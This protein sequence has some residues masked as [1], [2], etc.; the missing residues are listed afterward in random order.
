MPAPDLPFS[1]AAERNRGPILEV[2]RRVLPLRASVLEI[3]SGTGQHAEQRFDMPA[4]NLMLAF[5]RR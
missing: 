4:S 3:A 5:G 2:L 1:P